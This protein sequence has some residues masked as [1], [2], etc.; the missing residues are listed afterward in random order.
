[1]AVAAWRF[2]LAQTSAISLLLAALLVC[3]ATDLLQ[4]RVPDVITYPA[5]ALALIATLLMPDSQP[6]NALIAM[7]L[8]G[9]FFLVMSFVT[10]G[11]VGLGDVKLAML[12]GA[13]LGLPATLQAL[14]PGI[15][16]GGLV[17]L[18]LF[19]VGLVSRRQAVPY[20]PF[21]ALAAVLVVLLEGAS[22]APL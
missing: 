13:A 8:G 14:A 12:I 6:R 9:G 20:A 7:G 21:L 15:V 11:G 19:L 18:A 22:F 17:I 2:D 5:T 10:R 1:M 4:Y 16:A 3:T